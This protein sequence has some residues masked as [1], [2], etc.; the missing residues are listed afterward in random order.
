[1]CLLLNLLPRI[2]LFILSSYFLLHC[3]LRSWV[4]SWRYGVELMVFG[5]CG[6]G[7]SG[8]FGVGG[9]NKNKP[10][11]GSITNHNNNEGKVKAIKR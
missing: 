10:A 5:T 9:L 4:G 1:M 6:A 8:I 2:I 11:V 7:P 3:G